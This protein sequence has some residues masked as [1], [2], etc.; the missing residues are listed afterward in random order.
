MRDHLE[1]R[2]RN[3]W[4][5]WGPIAY[6]SVKFTANEWDGLPPLY[7]EQM[8]AASE[9]RAELDKKAFEAAK[10]KNKQST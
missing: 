6:G 7:T 8:K 2:V 1:K 4:D 5:Y 10:R 9:V 3:N